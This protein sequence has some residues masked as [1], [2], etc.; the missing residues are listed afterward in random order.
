MATRTAAKISA[1]SFAEYRIRSLPVLTAEE[2]DPEVI[3]I[4]PVTRKTFRAVTAILAGAL[5]FVLLI[6]L[7]ASLKAPE[8]GVRND[9]VTVRVSETAPVR[10]QVT[11]SATDME[12]A[13]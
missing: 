2:N 10:A 3:P 7:L 12:S 9:C 1:Y 4:G 8:A 6:G 13:S 5:L 11:V